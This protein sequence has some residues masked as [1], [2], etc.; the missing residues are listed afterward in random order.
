VVSDLKLSGHLAGGNLELKE[1]EQAEP[2]LV[3][4]EAAVDPTATEVVEGVMAATTASTT[5]SQSVEL[6]TAAA[7]QNR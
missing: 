6:A 2:L 4:E 5:L 7:G 1:L 3:G